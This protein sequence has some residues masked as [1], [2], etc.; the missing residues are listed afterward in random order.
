MFAILS[1]LTC[2]QDEVDFTGVERVTASFAEEAVGKLYESL[3]PSRFADRVVLARIVPGLGAVGDEAGD[4]R[5]APAG[6]PPQ[7]AS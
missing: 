1:S 5:P 7:S 2:G 4:D 3:G 6:S